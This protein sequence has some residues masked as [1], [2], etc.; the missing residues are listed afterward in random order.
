MP[1]PISNEKRADI[2]KHIQ[3]GESKEDV[4]KWLLV[5]LRT[6][7]RVMKRYRETGCHKALP[8]NGG[9]KPLIT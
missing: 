2:V 5:T 8:G 4:A 6:I 3:S 1:R 7:N 9:Q